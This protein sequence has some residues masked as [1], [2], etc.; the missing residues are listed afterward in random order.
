MRPLGN[1]LN[2]WQQQNRK[3]RTFTHENTTDTLTKKKNKQTRE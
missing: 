1:I 2:F 3:I